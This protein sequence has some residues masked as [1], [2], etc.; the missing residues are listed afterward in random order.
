MFGSQFDWDE[1]GA[2]S[3]A[4]IFDPD[5]VDDRRASVGLPPLAAATAE[6]RERAAAE[7][8][9]PPVDHAARKAAFAAFL[10]RTGWR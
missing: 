8:Q 10:T 3:P 1:D 5:G 2:L 9:T 4:P 6:M 7:G